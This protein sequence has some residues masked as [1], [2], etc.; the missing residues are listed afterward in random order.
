[1]ISAWICS[2]FLPLALSLSLP[3]AGMIW[4]WA[5]SGAGFLL[6][7][8]VVI[9]SQRVGE[10]LEAANTLRMFFGF[11]PSD[12]T[13]LGTRASNSGLPPRNTSAWT[14]NTYA[15]T[16]VQRPPEHHSVAVLAQAVPRLG[17]PSLAL[18]CLV[19]RYTR[20]A[21]VRSPSADSGVFADWPSSP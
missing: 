8:I 7:S 15:R 3:F 14:C 12:F 18:V 6:C 11:L 4:A 1:M 17:K 9:S 20:S 2:G 19:V 5:W 16:S 13:H 21:D 10:K